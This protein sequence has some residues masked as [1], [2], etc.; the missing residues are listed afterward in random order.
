M[1]RGR[2]PLARTT[3]LIVEELGDELLV[4]DRDTDRVHCLSPSA[5]A[6]W[7]RCDGRTPAGG[8]SAQLDLDGETVE[9]ALDELAGLGLLEAGEAMTDGT[10]RRELTVRLAKA[11]T[12]VAAAP[13]IVSIVAP[14]PAAALTPGCEGIN[15]CLE[16]C[17]QTGHGCQGASCVCCQLSAIKC[18]PP[19]ANQFR[20]TANVKWCIPGTD[21]NLCPDPK[22]EGICDPWP[23]GT[24][25]GQPRKTTSA[26]QSAGS[27]GRSASPSSPSS[28][29]S[30]GS[31]AP[32][33]ETPP[34]TPTV[35]AEPTTAPP[36]ESVP[37][38]EPTPTPTP[39]PEPT[40][41]PAV[42]PTTTTT[43]TTT[44]P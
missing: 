29:G 33:P 35:P 27:E 7:R 31:T 37:A 4:Y 36:P 44:T 30:T 11:G 19:N 9:R 18:P 41:A 17:G 43:T 39:A 40:P 8:L 42:E 6:V 38:P 23:P 21:A 16:D 20:R 25:C 15:T 5:A 1:D 2:K 28:T 22:T 13:L 32:T 14:T 34:S 3:N 26:T 10:T 12:A 24:V